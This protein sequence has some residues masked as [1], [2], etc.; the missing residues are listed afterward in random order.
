M[1]FSKCTQFIVVFCFF[2]CGFLYAQ[3]T[4]VEDVSVAKPAEVKTATESKDADEPKVEAGSEERDL[5][6]ELVVAVILRK[7]DKIKD[8]L[9]EGADV[10]AADKLSL[11]HIPS[12]RDQRGSRMPSSA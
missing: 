8:L 10:N 3:D 4:T 12:P 5:T 2:F 11:I 6:N 1:F 9:A 7:R